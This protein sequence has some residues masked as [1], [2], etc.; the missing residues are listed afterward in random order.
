MH[1][2]PYRQSITDKILITKLTGH[3]GANWF[4]VTFGDYLYFKLTFLSI[5]HF[6]MPFPVNISPGSWSFVF[7]LLVTKYEISPKLTKNVISP[8]WVAQW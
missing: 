8:E 7:F 5:T 6:F 4:F 3:S 2:Q 1:A